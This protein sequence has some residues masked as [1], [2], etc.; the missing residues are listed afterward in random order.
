MEKVVKQIGTELT[1]V[2]TAAQEAIRTKS[3]ADQLA[4]DLAAEIEEL[5]DRLDE[6]EDKARELQFFK[7]NNS[8]VI[9]DLKKALDREISAREG[10]EEAKK[11]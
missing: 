6:E 11:C 1:D 2:K 7:L 3:H 5:K 10:L 4:R 9:S 8:S